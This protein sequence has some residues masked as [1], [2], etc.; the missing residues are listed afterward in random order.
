MQIMSLVQN[1]V[2]FM[3]AGEQDERFYRIL[4]DFKRR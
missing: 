3:D 1:V 2:Y 4:T